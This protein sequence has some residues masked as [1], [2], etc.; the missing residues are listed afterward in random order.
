MI[1]LPNGVEV[2]VGGQVYHGE[3]PEAI[4]PEHLK[5]APKNGKPA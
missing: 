2:H 3:I 1:K 4:C 5:P